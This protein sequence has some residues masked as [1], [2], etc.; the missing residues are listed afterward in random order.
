[1]AGSLDDSSVVRQFENGL[2]CQSIVSVVFMA[3]AMTLILLGRRGEFFT[4]FAIGFIAMLAVLLAWPIILSKLSASIHV[5]SQYV[6]LVFWVAPCAIAGLLLAC[7]LKEKFFF[8]AGAAAGWFVAAPLIG[9]VKYLIHFSRGENYNAAEATGNWGDIMWILVTIGIMI[10]CGFLVMCMEKKLRPW[11]YSLFTAGLFS[12]AFG[13]FL[14]LIGAWAAMAGASTKEQCMEQLLDDTISIGESGHRDFGV[15]TWQTVFPMRLP[16]PLMGLRDAHLY[17]NLDRLEADLENI[18]FPADKAAAILQAYSK[19]FR[20]QDGLVA[21][22]VL[23]VC[24]LFTFV[25]AFRGCKKK[26]CSGFCFPGYKDTA[27]GDGMNGGPKP[28]ATSPFYH[29]YG[30]PRKVAE[31][32]HWESESEVSNYDSDSD[33]ELYMEEYIYE[34]DDSLAF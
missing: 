29:R 20:F 34:S 19:Q 16:L 14:I 30:G 1:M 15:W 6:F 5:E 22:G 27:A 28:T 3:F 2:Y 9:L 26:C 31:K 12:S 11:V 33:D 32:N 8:I 17:A 18:N 10:G 4:R 23:L 7:F 25:L 24:F 21:W 13:E